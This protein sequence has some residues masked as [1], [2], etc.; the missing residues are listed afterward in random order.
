VTPTIAASGTSVTFNVAFSSPSD[1]NTTNNTA[2]ATNA[3]VGWAPASDPGW[4]TGENLWLRSNAGTNCTVTGCTITT[5]A[6]QGWLAAAANAVTWLGTVTYDSINRINGYPT[7]Y[8]NGASLNTNNTLGLP[9]RAN[10]IFAVTKIA[11]GGQFLMGTQTVTTNARSWT[12]R[13]TT[14]TWM[15]NASTVYYNGANFRSANTPAI[16][17]TIRQTAGAS[18]GYTNGRSILTSADTTTFTVNNFGIGR[19][20][21]TNSTLT[22]LAEVIIYPT[23]ITLIQKNQVES[24]LAIK[25]G[26]TL[27]QTTATNYTYSNGSIVWNATTAGAYKNNIAGIGRDD[28]STLNH[29]ISQSVTNTGDIIVSKW[30]ITNNRLALLWWNDGQNVASF[31]GTDAPFGFNRIS[32]EWQFQEKNGDIGIVNIAYPTSSVP[33]GF[34]GT[35]MLLTDSDGV[36]TTG[37]TAYT[38]VINGSYWDFSVNITDMQYLTFAKSVPTDVTPPNITSVNIASW[39]LIPKWD[40]SIIANFSDTGSSIQPISFSGYIYAW[41][42]TGSTWSPMNIASG[43]MSITGSTTAST[44]QLWVQNL[45]FGKYRFD[46]IIADTLGNIRTQSYTYFIDAVEW[47][48]NAP[49]YA[50]GNVPLGSD[51]FGS[52]ELLITIKTVGAWFDLSMIR[53]DDLT[54]DIDVIWVYNGISWWWYDADIGSGY[55]GT[56]S[57]HGSSQ[58]L[59]STAKNINQNGQK[60]TFIYR[61]KYG[62]NPPS[63]APAGDYIWSVNFQIELTY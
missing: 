29:L 24:Y 46:I 11:T 36:F 35:L 59:I 62:V 13:P 17:S 20:A 25:Y 37:S 54:Y 51:S 14:D 22:N 21:N 40:F 10:S 33:S 38:G 34:T 57:P 26:I 55:S 48:I 30:Y 39:T 42:S 15:R 4:V 28:S 7:L 53:Q 44:G 5:W 3:V 12:T 18:A 27:D 9:T 23:A 31:T 56:I 47:T 52:G 16:T 41:D 1:S 6:N 49:T 19:I 60:N 61:V 58:N 50:I 2:F 32:R 43:Y 45:P 8:F 63:N